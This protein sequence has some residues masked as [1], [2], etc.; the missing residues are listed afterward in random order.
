MRE[1]CSFTHLSGRTEGVATPTCSNYIT[2]YNY[3]NKHLKSRRIFFF[4]M[5]HSHGSMA[6]T[7]LGPR[8]NIPRSYPHNLTDSPT[9]P[10][11]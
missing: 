1:R 6:P 3:N 11:L 8:Y 4:Y 7:A 5:R 2:S 9:E 10:A